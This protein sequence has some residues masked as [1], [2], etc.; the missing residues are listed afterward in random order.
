MAVSSQVSLNND[1]AVAYQWIISVW[2]RLSRDEDGKKEDAGAENQD[3]VGNRVG[4]EGV[5]D[6][7]VNKTKGV[8][9][10]IPGSCYGE[11]GHCGE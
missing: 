5:G 4:W 6:G 3:G 9:L 8:L 7:K 11:D 10:R 1:S 2:R